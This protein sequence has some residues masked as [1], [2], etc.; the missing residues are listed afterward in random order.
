MAALTPPP[1]TQTSLVP[2]S[3]WTGFS[4]APQRGRALAVSMLLHALGLAALVL[5]ARS[6]AIPGSAGHGL[7]SS[8][9][10][11]APP[12]SLT[13]TAP[14]RA[15]IGKEFSLE[16]LA[17]R[18]ALR[19][20]SAPRVAAPPTPVLPEPPTVAQ[21][22]VPA[23]PIPQLGSVQV[24]GPPPQQLQTEEKPKIAFET[25]GSPGGSVRGS[26]QDLFAKG[27]A[28]PGEVIAEATRASGHPSPSSVR[29]DDVDLAPSSG[30]L[31]GMRQRAARGRQASSLELLSDPGGADFRPYLMSILAIVK[32]NW[33]A[34]IPET[35]RLGR[36]GRVQILF[37]IDRSGSVPK[38][39]IGVPS[40]TDSLDRAAVAGVSAS[41]PF[42]PL[43][44]DFHGSQIKLQFTFT[45]NMR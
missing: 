7:R 45:Y 40:G 43:P 31:G 12:L 10:L 37:I 29:V 22:A 17:Q 41:Q 1:D 9:V 35:A 30:L 38:L 15:R 23:P 13:Q 8:T 42:P 16:S 20:P 26:G 24:P 5:L 28:P 36:Q 11:V 39:V 33:Q 4:P 44:Q 14:N 27:Y 25:P 3:E 2:I 32:R 34:V 19:V 21:A 6:D 18:P